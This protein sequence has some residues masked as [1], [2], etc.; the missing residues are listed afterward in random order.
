MKERYVDR[1][2][3]EQNRIQRD[4]GTSMYTYHYCHLCKLNQ[5]H[6]IQLFTD[7]YHLSIILHHTHNFSYRKK[8][9]LYNLS[10]HRC[11]FI[12]LEKRIPITL[13]FAGLQ[14]KQ[15]IYAPY[16]PFREKNIWILIYFP[17]FIKHGFK[18]C[19]LTWKII[20]ADFH[21]FKEKCMADWQ[22]NK[23]NTH[24]M[25]CQWIHKQ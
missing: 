8:N 15:I 11:S 3:S 16:N 19:D 24:L 13:S 5:A 1:G 9:K 21:P 25:I 2:I 17:L 23:L 7:I 18:T 10:Q 12:R 6:I 20:I 22:A 14:A 4:K